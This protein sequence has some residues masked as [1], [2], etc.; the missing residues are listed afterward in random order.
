M[1]FK[2]IKYFLTIA[3]TGSFTEAA[4][5]CYIS[6]SAVSQQINALEAELGVALFERTPRRVLLTDAGR[7]LYENGKK[8]IRSSEKLK[9]G[10]MAAAYKS[11]EQ[12]CVAYVTG[13]IPDSLPQALSTFKKQHNNVPVDV[14]CTGYITAF[15]ELVRREA[16]LVLAACVLPVGD[17]YDVSYLGSRSCFV[18]MSS[19]FSA[20][21]HEY[22]SIDDLKEL[23]CIIAAGNAERE[24]GRRYYKK[25]FGIKNTCLIAATEEEAELMVAAG[26]GFMLTDNDYFRP[27]IKKVPFYTGGRRAE[28]KYYLYTAKSNNRYVQDFIQIMSGLCTKAQQQ[29]KDVK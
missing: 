11:S 14:F 5:Q 24:A 15:S 27:G 3:E 19:M 22:V 17:D 10:V 23:P 18:V 7:Y 16:D 8:I 13:G 1:L 2:Q 6:Q 12:L 26:N 28:K 20:G 4:A 9:Q 25:F 29:D 21:L